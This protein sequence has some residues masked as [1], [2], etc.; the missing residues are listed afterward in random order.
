MTRFGLLMAGVLWAITI[1]I[2]RISL[3]EAA[4]S[5]ATPRSMRQ[6]ITDERAVQFPQQDQEKM[7]TD[8]AYRTRFMKD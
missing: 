4:D 6:I 8:E 5:A 1:C 2:P 3:G 7:R